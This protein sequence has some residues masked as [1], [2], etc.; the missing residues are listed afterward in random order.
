MTK[1]WDISKSVYILLC[2]EVIL[3]LLSSISLALSVSVDSLGIG[4]TYGLKNTRITNISKVILFAISLFISFLSIGIGNLLI[5][6]LP[7]FFTKL[8]GVIIIVCMGIFVIFQAIKKKQEDFKKESE[9]IENNTINKPEFNLEQK[10]KRI[11]KFF[12]RPLG[13]TIQIIRDPISGDLDN[14][15]NIDAKEAIFLGLAMS[16]DSFCIGIGTSMMGISSLLFPFMIA[17]FQL[18]FLYSGIYLGSKI[19]KHSN[20]PANIWNIISGGILIG[21]GILKI[22]I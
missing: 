15:Q 16:L 17:S 4:I 22:F 6:L 3:M 2:I 8:I 18:L 11:Y 10:E 20:L 9:K 13:I 5:Y 21:I 14:S 12:I 1:R 19:V 7:E